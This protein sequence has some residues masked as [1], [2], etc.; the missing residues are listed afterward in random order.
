MIVVARR[1]GFSCV[2]AKNQGEYIPFRQV[3][4]DGIP[5]SNVCKSA[6][7]AATLVCSEI[8]LVATLRCQSSDT[9]HQ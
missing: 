4:H 6:G 8:A 5:Q 1:D 2:G 7:L 9:L 3:A